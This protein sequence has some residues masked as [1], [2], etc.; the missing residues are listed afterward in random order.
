M[1]KICVALLFLLTFAP[2][3]AQRPKPTLVVV[4]VADQMRA[5][6]LTR[7]G[8]E[9]E[10]GFKTLMTGG[11][12]YQDAAY[13]YYN[14][15]T[16][17]GHTTIATGDLPFRHG[18]IGNA[19]FNRET[20]KAQT[21]NEDASASEVSYGPF[22]GSGDSAKWMLT[23]TL[24]ETMRKTMKS[25]VATMSIK[26]RSAIGLAGHEGDFVTWLDER[27]AWTTSSAYAE[28]PAVWFSAWAQANPMD[29][30]ADKNWDL[31]LPPDR[32]KHI[33]DVP[34]QPGSPGGAALFPHK[35]GP[36]SPAFLGHWLQ[37]PFADD[38]LEQMAE[39]AVTEMHLGQDADR[40]DFLGVS[41]SVLDIVG[42]AYGPRSDEVQDILVRLD[43][44]IQK[45]IEFLDKKVGAGRYVLA[46]SSDHGVADIPEEVPG[47]GRVNT[48]T[49]SAT[50][51]AAAKTVL[52]GD[53]G[54]IAA[55]NAGD[56]YFKPGVYDRLKQDPA[57][58]GAV[59]D[60]VMKIPGIARV[61]KGEE[62]STSAARTSK[63]ALIRAAALSYYPDRSGDLT[64]V[65]KENWIL[66]GAGTTH[67]TSYAYDQHVPVIL[68]GAGIRPGINHDAVTPAD[69]APTFA[70][71]LDVRLP[72]P[73]GHELKTAL[74][75]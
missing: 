26:A 54:Y 71:I 48:A 41:F 33:K 6:Y 73:D 15:V 27:G 21:C 11:A 49:V 28:A 67:G 9:F 38:Y 34:D 46:F 29:R 3:Q 25:R 32:Y 40:T 19:W 69:I 65:P 50:V 24:A 58:L 17:V 8:A 20:G 61:I 18:M 39:A 52:G 53:T 10:H 68:Y 63:D 56:V 57:A 37:S 43:A 23:P 2:A 47:A 22:K 66:A 72:E 42:H 12:W 4:L 62:I 1:R 51:D 16:C 44:T 64:I 30:D 36:K 60:A 74:A 59:I 31:T 7:Y 13:P 5:D 70:A 45:L 35:L 55:I 14:T 75:R